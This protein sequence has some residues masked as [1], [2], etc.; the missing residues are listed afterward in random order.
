MICICLFICI[1]GLISFY[2]KSKENKKKKE[3]NF[4]NSLG[5][6]IIVI[7]ALTA[8]AQGFYS[9]KSKESSENKIDS[10]NMLLQLSKLQLIQLQKY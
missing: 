6:S 2:E 5:L 3:S 1:G 8:F 4:Y 9:E 7:G 10:I